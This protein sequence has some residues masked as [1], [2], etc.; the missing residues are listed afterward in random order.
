[1]NNFIY[2]STYLWPYQ[3]LGLIPS[4]VFRNHTGGGLREPYEVSEM[5]L[6][7]T[8]CKANA[9]LLYYLSGSNSFKEMESCTMPII[10]ELACD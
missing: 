6:V 10:R 7:A 8:V 3:C 1:M 2:L 4:S 9:N 5:K